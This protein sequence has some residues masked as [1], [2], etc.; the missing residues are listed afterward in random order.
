MNEVTVRTPNLL[1]TLKAGSASPPSAGR[2]WSLMERVIQGALF[3]RWFA[4]HFRVRSEAD[5]SG[6]PMG[7]YQDK[8]GVRSIDAPGDPK[9]LLSDW[10]WLACSA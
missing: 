10:R 5:L 8:V 9:C 7:R 3:R 2:R 1:E 4:R 6:A